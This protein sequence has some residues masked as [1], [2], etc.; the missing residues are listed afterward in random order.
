MNFLVEKYDSA[1]KD[2]FVQLGRSEKRLEVRTKNLTRA[3]EDLKG[4]IEARE[5]A[6]AWEKAAEKKVEGLKTQL[7]A[8]QGEL[9]ESRRRNVA[10]KRERSRSFEGFSGVRGHRRE[11]KGCDDHDRE[12]HSAFQQTP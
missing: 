11:D 7:E 12:V 5:Q 2:T 4:G 10:L 6:I 9:G 3:I 1:L 8:A